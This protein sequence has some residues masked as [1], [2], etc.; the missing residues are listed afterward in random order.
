MD[1]R[2]REAKRRNDRRLQ[3]SYGRASGPSLEMSVSDERSYLRF[4]SLCRAYRALV[5]ESEK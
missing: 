3:T 1:V 4:D 2:A 5:I